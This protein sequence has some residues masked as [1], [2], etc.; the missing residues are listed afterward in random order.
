MFMVAAIAVAAIMSTTA[1]ALSARSS[2]SSTVKTAMEEIV[3]TY[4]QGVHEKDAA[5]IRSCFAETAIIR[6]VCGL[7]SHERTVPAQALVDRC[8]EFVAAHPDVEISFYYGPECGRN[9]D[10]VVAHWY[11]TG[12]WSGDSCGVPAPNPSV[13]MAVEG[14]T[15]FQ[16]DPI[17]LKIQ[18]FV[19]TR[20]FTEWEVKMLAMRS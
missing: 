11:E 10:W 12:T 16:V 4:F 15:R 5:K 18:E 7:N 20:T 2:S 17:S 19:V 1:R 6:D 13:P 14:Q 9:S 8:M 3:R